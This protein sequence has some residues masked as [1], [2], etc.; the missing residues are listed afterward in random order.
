MYT[1]PH[2]CLENQPRSPSPTSTYIADALLITD[3]TQL[4]QRQAAVAARLSA[5]KGDRDPPEITR[6]SRTGQLRRCI[7]ALHVSGVADRSFN[8]LVLLAGATVAAA[9]V[10]RSAK[11]TSK[12][13]RSSQFSEQMFV[14][15]N[16]K[17]WSV[18]NFSTSCAKCD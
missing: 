5:D 11:W 8:A 6:Y 4:S 2:L 12:R 17:L 13:K 7:R 18:D 1:A 14:S 16:T 9:H 10:D 15:A 3:M